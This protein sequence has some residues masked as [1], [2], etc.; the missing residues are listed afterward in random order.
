[1][2]RGLFFSEDDFA[3]ADELVVEPHT[4]FVGGAL[5]TDTR[6]PAEQSHA[7]RGLENIGRKRAAIDVEFDAKI[8]GVRDPRD[9]ITGIE[10]NDLGYESNKYGTLCHFSSAPC[11]SARR[12]QFANQNTALGSCIF[13]FPGGML[14]N[15]LANSSTLTFKS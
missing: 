9:L 12:W 3:L 5:K 10:Y 11:F 1:L 8:A 15:R 14:Y 7:C 4:I 6:R 13:S 2:L